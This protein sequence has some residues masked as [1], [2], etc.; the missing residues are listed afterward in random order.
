M[1][2]T[3]YVAVVGPAFAIAGAFTMISMFWFWRLPP[4]AGDE[5]NGRTPIRPGPTAA[6]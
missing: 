5:M 4:D 6:P 1:R 3:P 2:G